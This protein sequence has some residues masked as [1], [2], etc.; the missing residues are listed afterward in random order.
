MP[1]ITK[2][3]CANTYS[4]EGA[5]GGCYFNIIRS[6]VEGLAH[7]DV[8]WSCVRV[9]DKPIP[10]TWLSEIIAIATAHEGGIAGFLKNTTTAERAT[11]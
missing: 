2:H 8:G 1:K 10:I 3:K 5:K 11:L 4:G 7:L 6:D 9:Y